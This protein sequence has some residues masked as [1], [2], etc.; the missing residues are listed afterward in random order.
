MSIDQVEEHFQQIK[1]LY[2]N[3]EISREEYAN[4]LAGLEV[5]KTITLNSEEL[6][7]KE[8]LHTLVS[9]AITAASLV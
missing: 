7:R 3:N 6:Q 4:L 1:M 9:A 2:I 5:E 8:K